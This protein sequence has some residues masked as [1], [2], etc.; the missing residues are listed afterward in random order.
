MCNLAA[1]PVMSPEIDIQVEPRTRGYFMNLFRNISEQWLELEV[2]R[3]HAAGF[4]VIL[5][6]VYNNGWTLFPSEA[7]RSRGLPAI[8]PVLK[9]WDPLGML[10]ELAGSVGIS[11]WAFARP[12]DFHPRYSIAEHRLLKKYPGWRMCG[13]PSFQGSSLKKLEQK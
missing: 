9:K 2:Q 13:H 12:Y 8:N 11:V 6:P 10:V 7:M 5:F 3:I 4:N 1:M